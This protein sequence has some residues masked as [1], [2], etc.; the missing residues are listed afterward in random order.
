M[1]ISGSSYFF[2]EANGNRIGSL[3]P[4]TGMLTEWPVPTANSNPW[5]VAVGQGTQ[6]FFIER[7]TRQLGMLDTSQNTITEWPLAPITGIEHVTFSNGIVYFGDLN[8]SVVATFD[9]STNVLTSWKAPTPN[10][11]IPEV[12][13]SSGGL[14]N[15]AERR[16]NK[17]GLLDPSLQMGT[18]N[19]LTPVTQPTVPTTTKIHSLRGTLTPVTTVVLPTATVVNPVTTGGFTEW[20]VPTPS[21]QPFGISLSGGTTFFTEYNANQVATLVTQ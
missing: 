19:T 20:A 2:T 13:V 15:F 14:I 6:V 12:F 4:S 18:T 9:P 21:S 3:T 16:G 7:A 10:A 17:I 8:S 11:G 1:D 5:G